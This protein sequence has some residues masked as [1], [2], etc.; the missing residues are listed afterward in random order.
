MPAHCEEAPLTLGA[1][2]TEP[3]YYDFY[4]FPERYYQVKYPAPGPRT[5]L[6]RFKVDSDGLVC[7]STT[8]PRVEVGGQARTME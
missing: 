4:G 8:I 2:E 1:T 7:R 6:R 5:W 3:L